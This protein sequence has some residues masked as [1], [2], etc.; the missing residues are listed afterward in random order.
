MVIQTKMFSFRIKRQA[1]KQKKKTKQKKKKIDFPS[2]V[3]MTV[4]QL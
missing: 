3:E 1:A 4:V 2:E